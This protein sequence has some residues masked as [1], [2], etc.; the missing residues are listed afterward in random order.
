MCVNYFIS[1]YDIFIH[2]SGMIQFEKKS[3]N[4][5]VETKTLSTKTEINQN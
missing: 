1:G 4:I 5:S 3:L 2:L